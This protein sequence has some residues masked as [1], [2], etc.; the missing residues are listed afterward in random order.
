MGVCA[1]ST[2]LPPHAGA[3]PQPSRII[4]LMKGLGSDLL[5]FFRKSNSLQWQKVRPM[6]T[7]KVYWSD[8][9]TTVEPYLGSL[10]VFLTRNKLKIIEYSCVWE[11]EFTHAKLCQ[12]VA[13][14]LSKIGIYPFKYW[15]PHLVVLAKK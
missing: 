14:L 3:L 2:A 1:I 11:E 9:D 12:K 6:A 7:S 5:R 10:L 15:G 13:R 4:K 8:W